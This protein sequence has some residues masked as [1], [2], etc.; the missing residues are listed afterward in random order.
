MM[1]GL[2]KLRLNFT[3]REIEIEG[4]IDAI[5]RYLDRFDEI[6]DAFQDP[7]PVPLVMASPSPNQATAQE[8]RAMPTEFGEYLHQFPADI[9]DVDRILIAASF[10]QQEN[11]DNTFSTR[12]ANDLLQNQGVKVANA[13]ECVRRNV[14]AKRVF[15]VTKGSYRVSRNGDSHIADMLKGI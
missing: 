12:S 8:P 3:S 14:Q 7:N 2:A 11:P 5:D 9:T 10:T 1:S 13:S 4:S 15:A 6:I